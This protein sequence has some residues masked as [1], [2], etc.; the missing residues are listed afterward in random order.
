MGYTFVAAMVL[1]PVVL[2]L[3]TLH[4]D[5]IRCECLGLQCDL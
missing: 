2:I 5:R 4:A 3:V 1:V